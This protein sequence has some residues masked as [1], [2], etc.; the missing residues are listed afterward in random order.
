M[1]III[2]QN[3]DMRFVGYDIQNEC[4][5]L[6]IEYY[7]AKTL[8]PEKP[9][10]CVIDDRYHLLM[11]QCGENENYLIYKPF[12]L[13]NIEYKEGN[14]KIKVTFN[15]EQ[16]KEKEIYLVAFKDKSLST[17]LGKGV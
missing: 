10:H 7:I 17:I 12:D 1:K 15:N 14:K 2:N 13:V 6:E 3:K 4:N 5:P 8:K 11:Y 16:S 9:V